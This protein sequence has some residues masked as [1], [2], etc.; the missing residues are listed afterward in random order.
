[1]PPQGVCRGLVILATGIGVLPRLA[2]SLAM[3][4]QNPDLMMT[5][6][7][8]YLLSTPNPSTRS[9]EFTQTIGWA[10]HEFFDSDVGGA[11]ACVQPKLLAMVRL[12]FQIGTYHLFK[13]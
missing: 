12:I 6:S 11:S 1:M 4:T 2:A 10:F 5:D 9:V 7:E 3:H 13:C 8:A